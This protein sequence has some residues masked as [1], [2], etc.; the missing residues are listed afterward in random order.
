MN[1]S[2]STFKNWLVRVKH[3]GIRNS[4]SLFQNLKKD[5]CFVLKYFGNDFYLR[6]NTVDFA[7]FNSIFAKGEYDL[8]IGFKPE[9]II[10]AGAYTGVSTVYFRHKYREAKI[11]AVEPEKSN[12]DLLVRNT[13]PYK[14]I[15]CVNAGVYCEDIPL[16]I[17][18][19]SAEKYAFRV[20]PSASTEK[21]VPG[22]MIETL[23]KEFQLPHVDILKMDIEGAEYSVFA[24]N[25]DAWLAGVRVIVAELHEFIHPGVSELV[26]GVLK[27]SGFKI[28]W[29]GENL[30]ASKDISANSNAVSLLD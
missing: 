10:D 8:N 18:D 1:Y 2:I 22:Y 24:N 28:S 13:K 9:Y 14:N 29:K 19:H 25:P 15:F 26:L 12:F 7:V 5:G 11:I 3:Y 21:S 30:V 20:E 4:L 6:G 23:M 16:V 17:S 27:D